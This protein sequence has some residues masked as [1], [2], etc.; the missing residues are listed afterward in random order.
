MPLAWLAL[1]LVLGLYLSA[2]WAAPKPALLLLLGGA[3]GAWVLGRS[4]PL[5]VGLPLLVVVG[6]LLGLLRGGPGLLVP[7]TILPRFHGQQVELRGAVRG[8][9]EVVGTQ[10]RFELEAR[11]VRADGRRHATPGMLQVWA[12]AAIDP[13]PGRGHPFLAHGDLVTLDGLLDAPKSIG[14]FDYREHLAARGIG[15]ELRRATVVAIEPRHE[16]DL[17]G[18]VHAVRARFGQSLERHVPEP[19]A[20][21]TRALLLGLRGSVPPRITQEFRDSGMAHLLAVSGMHVGVLLG[22]ALLASAWLFGRRRS[23]YLLVPLVL[24]WLYIALAGAP[25]SAVRAGAMG[26]AYLLALATGRLTTPLNALGLAALALLIWDPA[27]LWDRSFQLSFTSMMGVLL[28]GLPLWR[29]AQ[30]RLPSVARGDPPVRFVGLRLLR[31][32]AAG[33]LVSVGAV[34]G[35]MPVVALNF[36]QVP[37]LGVLATPLA[38]PALPVLLVSGVVT[39]LLGLVAAPLADLA[40]LAPAVAAG[41]LVAEAALV[42]RVPGSVLE[43][44]FVTAGWVWASYALLFVVLAWVHRRR[45]VGPA[46]ELVTALWQGPRRRVDTFV[47]VAVFAVLATVPWSLAAARGDGLLHF[48]FLDVGQGDATLLRTPG[49]AFILIDGGRDPRVTVPLVDAVLPPGHPRIDVAVLTHPHRDHLDGL[50]ELA[51]RGRIERIF[52]PPVV[53]PEHAVW[54]SELDTLDLTVHIGGSGARIAF[55]DGVVLDLLNPPDP[56]LVGTASDV[57]NNG[58]VIRVG[59]GEAVVLLTGDLFADGE[60]LLIDRGEALAA[61]VLKIGHHGSDTSTNSAF[62][63][64]VSPSMAVISAGADNRLGHPSSDVLER[65]GAYVP[66]DLLFQTAEDGTIELTTDGSTWWVVTGRD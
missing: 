28:I 8:L 45:W 50:L 61:D 44:S 24:L 7:Q 9:P 43:A 63:R 11:E 49:G 38:L 51:R 10:V 20:A 2:E 18:W 16:A 41:F 6:V 25:P 65:V 37:M 33:V 14:P 23:A 39:A 59:L 47:V 57:D 46:L 64:A 19:Q 34:V 42:S 27:V 35:S 60:R 48:Y 3:G 54:R 22:L 13:V 17:M 29:R 53:E 56:P 31:A 58:L 15:S 66:G 30:D 21:L 12:D 52:V 4:V 26:S 40:G 36:Q 62:L 1:G 5:R 32:I 55:E